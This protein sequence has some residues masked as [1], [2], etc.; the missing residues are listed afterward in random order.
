M[1][2]IIALML[3]AF[4]IARLFRN[5]SPPRGPTASFCTADIVDGLVICVIAY[6]IYLI[7]QRSG[8]VDAAL[9][10]AVSQ[11]QSITSP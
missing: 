7:Y 5:V 1:I 10:K 11:S 8:E 9:N 6:S 4:M 2:P 3:G